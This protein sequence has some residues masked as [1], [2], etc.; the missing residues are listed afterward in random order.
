MT[1]SPVFESDSARSAVALI[2]RRP[3]FEKVLHHGLK[4]GI[5][6]VAKLESIGKD[7]PKGIVQIAR[8]FGSEFLRPELEKARER[9]INLVSLNLEW[10]S[11]GDLDTAARL[12][13][14]HSFMSRSKAASDMLK[15]LIVM[16]QNSHFGMNEHGAF[17]DQHIPQLAKWSLAS[18][19]DYRSELSRRKA[20]ALLIDA[21][22]WMAEG[23]GLE[24]EELQEAGPDA[25]AVI[26]TSLL[27]PASASKM[28][29]WV[30]FQK[31]ILALRQRKTPPTLRLPKG[32]PAEYLEVAE[33]I[34]L[35]MLADLPK[36]LDKDISPHKLFNQ[37]PAFVGR[38]FWM[39]DGLAEV[40]DFDREASAKW[41]QLTQGHS[42]DGSLLT[43]FVSLAVSGSGKTML[44][45]KAA[46]SLIRK[47][48]KSGWDPA[49][50][51]QFIQ[52][53]APHEL[54]ADYQGLWSQFA[55]EAQST[56]LSDRDYKLHDA[57][58]LLRHHC[59]ISD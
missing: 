8:Y 7:A 47:I 2:D 22:V 58:A 32:L 31:M 29:D 12:L 27:M 5:V 43:L 3:F 16:P 46:T 57:L 55:E 37:T 52:D 50:P 11:E 6:G 9:I 10:E 15:A 36:L 38:Y 54:Q 42:Y 13:H 51:V 56:L 21:A 59:N 41:K 1:T 17:N 19:A 20:V 34:R 23:L 30:G 35:S 33:R 45:E 48:R 18:L 25:E 28:P 26:R 39:E 4:Q 24:E 44:T 49:V 53:H 14:E 40:D